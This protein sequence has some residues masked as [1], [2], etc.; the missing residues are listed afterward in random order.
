MLS[1]SN[2]GAWQ[3]LAGNRAVA[4]LLRGSLVPVQRGGKDHDDW[5]VPATTAEKKVTDF[6]K[7]W[8]KGAL[9]H[10]ISKTTLESLGAAYDVARQSRKVGL[11]EVAAE[12]W[13]AVQL[14]VP[15]KV[16]LQSEGKT[17]NVTSPGSS[18]SKCDS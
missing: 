18:S 16:N 10:K 14:A 1:R 8:G 9:H 15:K 7:D 13:R 6:P 11:G 2:I 17:P 3:A 4:N 5:A 12:F